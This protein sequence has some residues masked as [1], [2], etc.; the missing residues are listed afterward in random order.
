MT[1]YEF[2]L[3]YEKLEK[4]Y[5]QIYGVSYRK[6]L[7]AQV[8]KD[9]D[10]AWFKSIVRRIILNPFEKISIDDAARGER[11]A[12]NAVRRAKESIGAIETLSSEISERGFESVL[13]MFNANSLL[14]A[15][16][17]SKSIDKDLILKD[18][19]INK[20]QTK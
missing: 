15:I 3:E 16:E 19:E 20:D 9:L 11:N 13:K 14:E 1:K 7:V 4:A 18:L 17:N 2:D 5:P 12:R 10:Y 6:E 8:V